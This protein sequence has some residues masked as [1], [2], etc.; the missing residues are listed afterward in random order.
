MTFYPKGLLMLVA[1]AAIVILAVNA[2][3]GN[4]TAAFAVV[5]I[6]AILAIEVAGLFAGRKR[7]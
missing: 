4:I 5:G 1:F 7:T 2:R 6:A 3:A